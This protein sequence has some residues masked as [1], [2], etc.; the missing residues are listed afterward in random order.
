MPLLEMRGI[1]K[2]F[3]DLVANNH[4][5]LHVERGEIDALV[6]ENGADKSTLMKILYGLY[7]PDEGSIAVRGTRVTLDSPRHAIVLGIGMV[8]QHFMLIPRF[9]VTEN[10]IL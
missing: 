8:H 3:G 4:V 6:G 7:Q 2:R 5:D 9:T 1:C 10:V